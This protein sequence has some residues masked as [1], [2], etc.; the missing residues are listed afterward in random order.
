[1]WTS[2]SNEQRRLIRSKFAI[3]RSGN[4]EVSDG[5]VLTDGTTAKDFEALTIQKMQEYVS[6]EISDFHKLFDLVVAKIQ[7]EI[8]GETWVPSAFIVP[9]EHKI[10]KKVKSKKNETTKSK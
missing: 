4:V 1:M 7:T 3:P 5:R 9:E 10:V 2:L 8:E 6:S